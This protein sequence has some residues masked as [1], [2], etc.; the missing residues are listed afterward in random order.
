MNTTL[1]RPWAWLC[2][3]G[4]T[5]LGA[6]CSTDSETLRP[7]EQSTP[8]LDTLTE[9]GDPQTP[10]SLPPILVNVPLPSI[11]EPPFQEPNPDETTTKPPKKTTTTTEAPTTTKPPKKTTTTTE[12]PTTTTTA[13]EETTTTA[14]ET[15]TT[16]EETTTTAEETTTT[17]EETTTTAEE[18]T[19]TAEET[20]TTA[21]ETTTTAEETTT[22]VEETTTT[23]EETTTTLADTTTTAPVV[24]VTPGTDGLGEVLFGGAGP[25]V[26]GLLQAALGDPTDTNAVHFTVDN[27]DGT[28]STAKGATFTFPWMSRSCYSN[29]ICAIFGGA[30][31]N[32]A[33]HA[34]VGWLTTE[35]QFV[36]ASGIKVGDTLDAFPDLVVEPGTCPDVA[37]TAADGFRLRLKSNGDPFG[38]DTPADRSVIEITRIES[39]QVST[40]APTC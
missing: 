9:P 13:P 30:K 31:K 32:P 26:L 7:V 10:D 8:V 6:A 29:G 25:D 28:F 36:T 37:Y 3:S 12:E 23:A 33:T 24:D 19:T 40:P 4:L 11:T 17:A 14:E 27:N 1:R 16:A 18:T 15:T 20:T 38:P 21:E 2:L 35:N 34:F 5:L 39:G 22:T